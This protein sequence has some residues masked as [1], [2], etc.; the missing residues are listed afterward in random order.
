MNIKRIL[1]VVGK[2]ADSAVLGG[3]IQNIKEATDEHPSGK[4]DI[5]KLIG[6]LVPVAI[7]IY[8]LVGGD[9]E[10]AEKAVEVAKEASKA[11]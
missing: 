4:L 1:K 11:L 8:I 2:V 6:A 9:S 3:A 7:V 10:T 5:P